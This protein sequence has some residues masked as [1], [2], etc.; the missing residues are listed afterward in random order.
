MSLPQ[1]QTTLQLP[2]P[3][4]AL[5]L[6]SALVPAPAHDEVLVALHAAALNPVD[7]LLAARGLFVTDFPAVLGTDGAGVVV[8]AGEGVADVVVGDRV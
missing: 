7:A 5:A 1:T 4:A 3:G 8:A 6:V 2:A